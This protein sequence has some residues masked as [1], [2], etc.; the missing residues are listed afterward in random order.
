MTPTYQGIVDTATVHQQSIR[1][2]FRL[3]VPVKQIKLPNPSGTTVCGEL[4]HRHHWRTMSVDFDWRVDP[5]CRSSC[6]L[7]HLEGRV[8]WSACSCTINSDRGASK[9]DKHCRPN[10][11]AK[12]LFFV[13]SRCGELDEVNLPALISNLACPGHK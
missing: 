1:N 3:C 5:D 10:Q 9:C 13:S 11:R 7:V 2:L 8:H 4:R 6:Q 12:D